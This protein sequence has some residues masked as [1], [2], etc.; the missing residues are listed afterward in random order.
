MS[1][2]GPMRDPFA[3]AP[4]APGDW[5]RLAGEALGDAS[6]FDALRG[7]LA[8]GETQC[9]EWCPLCRA[10]DLLR[11][12]TTPELREQWSALQREALVTVRALI[13][14]HLERIDLGDDSR[15]P[16]VEDIPVE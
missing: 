15:A 8:E 11:A 9:V 7:H 13:D 16:K 10:A 4:G 14:H 2:R 12:N 1:D 3:G 6:A 5:T